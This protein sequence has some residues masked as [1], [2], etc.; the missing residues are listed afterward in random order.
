M[1]INLDNLEIAKKQAQKLFPFIEGELSYYRNARSGTPWD[2]SW[3]GA[4]DVLQDY[5]EEVKNSLANR[6]NIL[7]RAY[8]CTRVPN[9]EAIRKEG[10]L[11]LNI[12]K[13]RDELLLFAEGIFWETVPDEVVKKWI[14]LTEDA[15][16]YVKGRSSSPGPAFTLGLKS[17]FETAVRR[18]FVEG[19]ETIYHIAPSLAWCLK[20]YDPSFPY[21]GKEFWIEY[22]KGLIP[23]LVICDLH[24]SELGGSQQ[25]EIRHHIIQVWLYEETDGYPWNGGIEFHAGRDIPGDW[26]PHILVPELNEYE[27][28]FKED[29]YSL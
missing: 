20:E 9:I 24:Y 16:S 15:T 2:K 17:V 22:C 3:G 10:L 21:E 12:Q 18:Y 27:P 13:M 7:L 4:W 23:A 1:L 5:D 8:H 19:S 28:T 6:Q 26:I 25:E 14:A 11:Q 29:V